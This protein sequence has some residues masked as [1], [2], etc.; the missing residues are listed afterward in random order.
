MID[1]F[2]TLTT[3]ERIVLTHLQDGTSPKDIARLEHVSIA[4][5]RAQIC[6]IFMKLGVNTQ[7]AAVALANRR[8][9]E[10]WRCQACE[11][12]AS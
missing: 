4:T 2:T 6:S 5:I 11:A 7:I 3:R 12:V 9:Q 1:R 10:Q 8:E